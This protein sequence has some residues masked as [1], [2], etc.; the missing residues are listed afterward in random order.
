MQ[1]SGRK[2]GIL[3]SFTKGKTLL[4]GCQTMAIGDF[5]HLKS[6][7]PLVNGYY[8]WP[9]A[10]CAQL[11]YPERYVLGSAWAEVAP[12]TSTEVTIIVFRK[13]FMGDASKI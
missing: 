9:K 3:Y 11:A 10:P 2:T 4:P 7:I 5:H 8:F 12:A 13:F 6:K 1:L